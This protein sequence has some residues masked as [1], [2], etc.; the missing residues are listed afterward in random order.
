M[1]KKTKVILGLGFALCATLALGACAMADTTQDDLLSKGYNV[2]VSYELNGGTFS[3]NENLT[4][5]H[6]YPGK[7]LE[8]GTLRLVEPGDKEFL[9]D[10]LVNTSGVV[11]GGYIHLGWYTG[12]ESR[13]D[14][15]G[16]PLDEN[17]EL[18]DVTGKTQGHV[19]SDRWDFAE[20]RLSAD[21]PYVQK[22]GNVYRFTLYAAWAPKYTFEFYRQKTAEEAANDAAGESPWLL[23]GSFNSDTPAEVK[24]PSWSE[25]TGG[26]D[27][28]NIPVYEGHTL[29]KIYADAN[30]GTQC[31]ETIPSKGI[32]HTGGETD[33]GTAEQMIVRLYTTWT[34]GEWFHIK[35]AS[36][37]S[38]SFGENGCYE[39]EAD[40]DF[41]DAANPDE[42]GNPTRLDWNGGGVRFSGIFHGNGHTISNLETVQTDASVLVSGG[43]F[44][45][46]TAE[47]EITDV[48]FRDV[49][50]EALFVSYNHRVGTASY[51]LFAGETDEEA[52]VSGVK[53]SGKV[54]L[55]TLTNMDEDGGL[56]CFAIG[57]VSGNGVNKEIGYENVSVE[58]AEVIVDYDDDGLEVRGWFVKAVVGENGILTI[59]HNENQQEDPNQ[60]GN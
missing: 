22:D 9:D 2:I 35:T 37:L 42:E 45:A 40:L 4:V 41:L 19:F 55:G 39:I 12:M 23:Y 51:G 11:R 8:A 21:S 5:V 10:Y 3:G 52:T 28:G 48:T 44:G 53:L 32:L 54:V 13:T 29:D 31:T 49:R 36:Q 6:Y 17:G 16:N 30:L 33:N 14:A 18:C 56:D 59:T 1:N 46:I 25:E 38:K 60:Q 27:Y 34:D 57:L 7:E 20:D 15:S 26:L 24:I 47:A 43:V 58:I 50:Y